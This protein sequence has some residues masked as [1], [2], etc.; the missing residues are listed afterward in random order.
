[1]A[2]RVSVLTLIAVAACGTGAGETDVNAFSASEASGRAAARVSC[3]DGRPCD[4]G[5]ACTMNDTCVQG[6][7][8]GTPY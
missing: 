6:L 8:K 1:M 7:C 2:L 4:D 3:K 5:L